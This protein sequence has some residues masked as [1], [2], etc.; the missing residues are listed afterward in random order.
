MIV[1]IVFE[2]ILMMR[3]KLL[4]VIVVESKFYLLDF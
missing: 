3:E 1:W 2:N 4:F